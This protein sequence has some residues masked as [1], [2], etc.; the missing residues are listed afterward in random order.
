LGNH[1][2]DERTMTENIELLIGNHPFGIV[3]VPDGQQIYKIGIMELL[4]ISDKQEIHSINPSYLYF[5]DTGLTR[6]CECGKHNIRQLELDISKTE[7][8]CLHSTRKTEDKTE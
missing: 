2:K 7:I 5:V 6:K 4:L 1:G 8:N 3:S